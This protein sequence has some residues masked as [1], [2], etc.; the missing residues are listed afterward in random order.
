MPRELA[1]I[2]IRSMLGSAFDLGEEIRLRTI[3]FKLYGPM[4]ARY[5]LSALDLNFTN[6]STIKYLNDDGTEFH[7]DIELLPNDKGG[8][9]MFSINCPVIP[10]RT[11]FPAYIGRAKITEGQNLRKRCREYLTKFSREDERPKITTLFKYWSKE[12]WL[13]FMPLE[14]NDLIVDYEKKLINSL[15]LPFNDEIPDI[16]IRA[17][18]K[19][20]QI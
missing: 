11:E 8:L 17:A 6:W 9:Y 7:R 10:G 14:D 12:L 1:V 16:E 2:F 3:N 20:F 5:D 4:W 19:A 18:V 13:S 15:L